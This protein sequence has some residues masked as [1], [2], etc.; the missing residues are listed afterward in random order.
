MGKPLAPL[1]RRGLHAW[2]LASRGLTLGVRGAVIDDDNR[3]LLIRHT[4]VSGW[5]MPGGGVEIGEDAVTALTRELAEEAEVQLGGTPRLHGIFFNGRASRRDHVLVYVVRDFTIKGP[6][7]PDREIAE[8]ALFSLDTLPD[9]INPGTRARLDEIVTG[10]AA[11][12][13]W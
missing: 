4:Y 2:F 12:A 13:H 11:S 9:G 10:R 7:R 5:H 6:K 3:V 8:A 1:V